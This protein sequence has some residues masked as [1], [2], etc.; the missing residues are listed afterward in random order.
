MPFFVV[1][2]VANC[3]SSSMFDVCVVLFSH[4]FNF[5]LKKMAE[6]P[7]TSSLYSKHTLDQPFLGSRGKC[8]EK[9]GI[10]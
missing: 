10:M 1:N 6:S 3:Y 7:A 8:E 2:I 5:G 9:C 4:Q